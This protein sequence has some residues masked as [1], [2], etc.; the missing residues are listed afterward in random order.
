MR[1][2]VIYG[3]TSKV[4]ARMLR[5]IFSV[6]STWSSRGSEHRMDFILTS[7]DVWNAGVAWCVD[8]DFD[9]TFNGW[10]DHFLPCARV[11]LPASIEAHVGRNTHLQFSY[12]QWRTHDTARCDYFAN[13]VWS[14]VLSFG[15]CISDDCGELHEF[16]RG[17]SLKAFG[18]QRD[19]SPWIQHGYWTTVRLIPPCT[20]L[21]CVALCFVAWRG[22]CWRPDGAS[23]AWD[24]SQRSCGST[25]N[26][27]LKTTVR[28]TRGDWLT[29]ASRAAQSGDAMSCF[30]V[31]RC[32]RLPA[33]ACVT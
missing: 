23:M 19:S 6:G 18:S 11:L 22:C 14:F 28:I 29:S 30:R 26:C 16:V 7:A 3:I 27:S 25:A 9:L 17:A 12:Y 10:T 1:M 5:T 2:V 33:C 20:R 32:W 21:L 24:T 4:D 15:A 13:L 8:R 31:V